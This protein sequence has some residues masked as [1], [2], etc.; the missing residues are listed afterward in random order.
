MSHLFASGG[1]SIGVS[2]STSVPPMSTKQGEINWETGI[3]IYTQLYI[4]ER[5]N[6][7][8][9]YSTGTLLSAMWQSEW[10]RRLGENGHM[11]IYG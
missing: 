3:D 5:T 1:Q 8:L 10:E 7:V 9:V 11:Y 4:K 2:A 6:K